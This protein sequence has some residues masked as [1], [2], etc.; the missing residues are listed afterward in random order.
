MVDIYMEYLAKYPDSI[1]FYM[2]NEDDADFMA[3]LLNMMAEAL[4]TGVPLTN[5]IFDVPDGADM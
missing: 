4:R 2:I 5:A 1:S 3:N